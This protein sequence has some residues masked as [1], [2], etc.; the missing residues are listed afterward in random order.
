MPCDHI[1]FRK[2]L[3]GIYSQLGR[4]AWCM[5]QWWPFCCSQAYGLRVGEDRNRWN[6]LRPKP[7]WD[8]QCRAIYGCR[9]CRQGVQLH[10]GEGT[11]GFP[12]LRRPGLPKANCT[13]RG[14]KAFCLIE[15]AINHCSLR[16]TS[17]V[18]DHS[19]MRY[20][21]RVF[22]REEDL[23]TGKHQGRL[24]NLF[25]DG[26]TAISVSDGHAPSSMG[27][28]RKVATASRNGS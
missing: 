22:K 28:R 26:S 20:V 10:E 11:K 15:N 19:I 12:R 24:T 17:A 5:R 1:L 9:Y 25:R 14:G 13:A 8:R 7:G 4:S 18:Q 6:R 2:C 16:G 3:E 23:P 27:V 21:W